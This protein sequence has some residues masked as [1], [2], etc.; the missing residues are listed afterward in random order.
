MLLGDLD[1]HARRC[2]RHISGL[3]NGPASAGLIFPRSSSGRFSC[4]RARARE[5]R[6]ID[7][8]SAHSNGD[9]REKLVDRCVSCLLRLGND[10]CANDRNRSPDSRGRRYLSAWQRERR[11]DFACRDRSGRDRAAFLGREPRSNRYRQHFRSG[12]RH[13]VL[14]ARS[15]ARL[16]VWFDVDL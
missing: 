5:Q 9:E 8:R 12:D 6:S 10:G 14:N 7:F 15:R 16:N 13:P 2:R 4:K 1:A 3:K 11:A